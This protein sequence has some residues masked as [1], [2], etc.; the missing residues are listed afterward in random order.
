MEVV[1]TWEYESREVAYGSESLF[2]ARLNEHELTSAGW[3]VDTVGSVPPKKG[4]SKSKEHLRL[5]TWK[6]R[7]R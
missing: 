1:M 2:Q 4:L 6:R 5:V 3:E 7:K